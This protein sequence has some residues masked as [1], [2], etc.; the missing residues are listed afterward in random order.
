ME[1]EMTSSTPKR[2]PETERLR[3][4]CVMSTPLAYAFDAECYDYDDEGGGSRWKIV[5]PDWGMFEP[6]ELASFLED[7][8]GKSATA[9]K[10]DEDDDAWMERLLETTNETSEEELGLDPMMS[11]AYP[12][13]GARDPS[14]L[15]YAVATNP[16]G[17]PLTVVEIGGEPYLALT[18]GGMDLSW[19]ICAA[20]IACGYLPPL[21]FAQHLPRMAG[22]EREAWRG[23][24][25]EACA[26]SAAIARSWAQRAAEDIERMRAAW[27]GRA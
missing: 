3:N 4:D 26:L 14:A 13:E 21:H 12:L 10:E 15:A 16:H 18:G 19:E 27:K 17:L 6:A 5:P 24:V 1:M 20:Y 23:P 25:L 22:W 7:T 9:R 11:Y 2:T 8:A